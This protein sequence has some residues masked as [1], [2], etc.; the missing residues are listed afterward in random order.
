MINA[1]NGNI[2]FESPKI[3][4]SRGMT[5][6]QFRESSFFSFF[7]LAMDLDPSFT[8]HCESTQANNRTFEVSVKFYSD[9]ILRLYLSIIQPSRPPE[10]NYYHRNYLRQTLGN[11]TEVQYENV[12]YAFAWGSIIVVDIKGTESDICINYEAGK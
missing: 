8:Y 4:F 5:I 10:D 1:N 9:V 2:I 7:K 12:K 6:L 11:P 3:E